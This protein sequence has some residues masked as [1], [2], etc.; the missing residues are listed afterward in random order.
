MQIVINK[1]RVLSDSD[2]L[3]IYDSPEKIL[4]NTISFSRKLKD[5]LKPLFDEICIVNNDVFV[6]RD[7]YKV[8]VFSKYMLPSIRFK[9]KNAMYNLCAEA[10][11]TI[12]HVLNSC[13]KM[14]LERY[15]WRHDSIFNFLAKMLINFDRQCPS[16]HRFTREMRWYIYIPRGYYPYDSKATH[17]NPQRNKEN[18][19]DS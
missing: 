18:A 12:H 16:I 17:S 5:I 9:R 2:I 6:L 8:K 3:S 13:P 4:G 19:M 1:Y 14:M 15:K 10:R 7:K 11:E